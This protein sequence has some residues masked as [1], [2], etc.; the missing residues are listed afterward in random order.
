MAE[1]VHRFSAALDVWDHPLWREWGARDD[2]DAYCG[3]VR[4][5][6]DLRLGIEADYIAGREDRM[7]ALLDGRDWDYVVGSVHFLRDRSL[8]TEEYSIWGAGD[9]S[10]GSG[11]ATSRPSP[12]RL[13][14]ASTTSSPTRTS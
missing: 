6:T 7:A 3:F 2:L 11:A 4:E 14:P 5:A 9:L 1:H 8:D 12:S 10:S 13:A